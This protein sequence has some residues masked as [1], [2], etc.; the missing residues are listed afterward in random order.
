ML[1]EREHLSGEIVGVAEGAV[2]Q[3]PAGEDREE[4]LDLIGATRRAWG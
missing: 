1:D 3:Q 2:A 4:A